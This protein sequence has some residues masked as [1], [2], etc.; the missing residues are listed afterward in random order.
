MIIWR[1]AFVVL[2]GI[3][4]VELLVFVA[5]YAT[6]SHWRDTPAGKA[7]LAVMGV[8]AGLFALI[9]LSRLLGGLGAVAWSV[10]LLVLD[11][12]ILQ[13]LRLLHREQR[14]MEVRK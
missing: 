11:V 3:G 14:K 4:L 1:W 13:W 8:L 10:A 6:K 7:L 5:M 2:A 12:V 9:F